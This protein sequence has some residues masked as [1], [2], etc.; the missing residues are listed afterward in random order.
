MST[1]N[2]QPDHELEVST[3][4]PFDTPIGPDI[5]DLL[6]E[7]GR[8][9]LSSAGPEDHELEVSKR[10]A[11]AAAD[12]DSQTNGIRDLWDPFVLILHNFEDDF[13]EDDWHYY[14]GSQT[15]IIRLTGRGR[16]AMVNHYGGRIYSQT[17]NDF[18]ITFEH[19]ED[20]NDNGLITGPDH[21]YHGGPPDIVDL[22]SIFTIEDNDFVAGQTAK[23]D[24][25]V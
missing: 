19:F 17:D 8:R 1:K 10:I 15:W 6:I 2:V 4:G 16:L 22:L 25:N 24:H 11:A 12:H 23:G 18:S 20:D 13:E 5:V 14:P 21:I 3:S 9:R 7:D